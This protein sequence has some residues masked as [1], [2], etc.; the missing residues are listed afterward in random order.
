MPD[1]GHRSS[2]RSQRRPGTAQRNP[3]HPGLLPRSR[4]R[5]NHCTQADQSC[6]PS[7]ETGGIPHARRCQATHLHRQHLRIN[8]DEMLQVCIKV[9][10]DY[11]D[12]LNEACATVL[13]MMHEQLDM[14]YNHPR[15]PVADQ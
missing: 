15:V 1:I 11:P 8:A 2:L 12:A 7:S 4:C 10:D 14:I 3:P 6:P 5:D 9:R 13:A